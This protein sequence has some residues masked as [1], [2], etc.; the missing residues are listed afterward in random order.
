MDV[1][2]ELCKA[3]DSENDDCDGSDDE[4]ISDENEMSYKED[5]SDDI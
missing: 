4:S 2:V 5:D 3:Y 1:N